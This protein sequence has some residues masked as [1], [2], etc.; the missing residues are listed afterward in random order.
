MTIKSHL[1]SKVTEAQQRAKRLLLLRDMAGLTRDALQKRYKL[2]RGTLQNW[3][4]ARFGGLTEKGAKL[5]AQLYQAE[6]IHCSV[7]W[8]LHG[9]GPHPTCNSD[10]YQQNTSVLT[11]DPNDNITKEILYFRNNNPN[12]I[13][14]VVSDDSM[15]PWFKPGDMI[16]GVRLFNEEMNGLLGKVCII[17]T[18]QYGN[19]LRVLQSGSHEGK[20]NLQAINIHRHGIPSCL[21]DVTVISAAPVMWTRSTHF[22]L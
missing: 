3:E 22:S 15:L 8:I 11:S 10:H 16:M 6:S 20:Y 21:S 1:A 9:I 12:A 17:Q 14:M 13:D 4:S 7:D 2:A 19:I 5:M 18:Q